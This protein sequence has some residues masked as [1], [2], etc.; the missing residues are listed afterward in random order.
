MLYLYTFIFVKYILTLCI[1]THIHLNVCIHT[2]EYMCIYT[3]TQIYNT[4]LYF[5]SNILQVYKYY[6][7][8]MPFFDLQFNL[9]F[10]DFFV[11]FI[12]WLTLP[13]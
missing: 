3:N 6:T 12:T 4:E 5:S 1:N 9:I 2:F 7:E 13:E 10:R 8:L 11:S